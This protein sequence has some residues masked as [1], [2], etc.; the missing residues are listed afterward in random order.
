MRG[1]LVQRL[2]GRNRVEV[3]N[4]DRLAPGGLAANGHLGDVHIVLAEERPDESDQTWHIAVTEQQEHTVKVG[5]ETVGAEMGE[6]QL[7]VPEQGA[8]GAVFLAVSVD[9]YFQ[10][11]AKIAFF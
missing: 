10:Q 7:P 8:G 1:N 6:S 5:I 11:R 4:S 9:N 2:L 3:E